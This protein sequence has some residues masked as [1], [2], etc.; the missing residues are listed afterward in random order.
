MAPMKQ[1]YGKDGSG[2]A[3]P[4][5]RRARCGCRRHTGRG[6]QLSTTGKQRDRSRVPGAERRVSS[7]CTGGSGAGIWRNVEGEGGARGARGLG[8]RLPR[9]RTTA[10]HATAKA[11]ASHDSELAFHGRQVHF[12]KRTSGA[13][14]NGKMGLSFP[15]PHLICAVKASRRVCDGVLR[16][17]P[18]QHN[19]FSR[20]PQRGP[21]PTVTATNTGH[22]GAEA[23]R[24]TLRVSSV[25]SSLARTL[26]VMPKILTTFTLTPTLALWRPALHSAISWSGVMHC[27]RRRGARAA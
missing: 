10:H 6:N 4:L 25:P 9:G 12:W 3:S 21:A 13:K 1:S 8:Q 11:G 17:A 7:Q 16:R 24:F 20:H 22:F 23:D 18:S 5:A 19:V 15:S 2:P 27:R 26:P 14:L